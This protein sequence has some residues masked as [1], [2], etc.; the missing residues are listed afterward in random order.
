MFKP[1][2][3]IVG[4]PN[5]GKSTLFNRLIGG[6]AAI[7]DDSPGVTRDRIYRDC[8]WAGR[9]FLLIDTGGLTANDADGFSGHVTDQV[10]LALEEADVIV[11]VVDGKSGINP[12]DQEVANKLRRMK[13]HVILAVNKIDDIR[14]L[15]NIADFYQLG[16]GDPLALSALR[17]SGGVGDLLDKVVEHFP[18]KET[19]GAEEEVTEGDDNVPKHF[20]LAIVGR[21]NVG[22]SSMVNVLCGHKRAIVTDKPGTTRDA[23]DTKIKYQGREITLVD[24]AGIRRRSKVDYGIEAFSVVRSLSSLSRADV[25]ALMLD[26]NEPISDQDKKIA[27]K[28]YEAGRPCVIVVNKWDLIEDK[29]SK[30]MNEFRDNVL[31]ELNQINYAEVVFT[32]ATAKQRVNKIIE[33]AE[34][35]LEQT[36]KRVTTGLLN[37]VLNEAAALVPPPASKRGN[38]LRIYYSTQVSTTPP[39]FVLFVNDAKL[40]NKSY[41]T[42]LERKLRESFGFVGTPIRIVCRSKDKDK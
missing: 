28:T 27:G 10:N 3:T 2:V 20:S 13:K 23:L 6:R 30:I 36:H 37:Q 14:E 29:S 1:V 38:R 41:E 34:R 18:K 31:A 39:T 19:N 8:D 5:V 32:S 33:A 15:N 11:F 22:K 7:V 42:Y 40:L 26:A 12:G 4:R 21:P 25:T 9:Q 17:G 24:T 16:L 35:A